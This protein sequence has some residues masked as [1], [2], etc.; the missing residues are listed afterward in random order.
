VNIVWLIQG[1]ITRGV[2]RGGKNPSKLSGHRKPLKTIKRELY[3]QSQKIF[4]DGFIYIARTD[5]QT[6]R[7]GLSEGEG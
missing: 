3:G 2:V 1:N 5:G 7:P 6:G 4:K